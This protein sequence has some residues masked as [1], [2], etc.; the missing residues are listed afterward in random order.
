MLAADD[1]V[2]VVSGRL[3]VEVLEG[4]ADDS[5]EALEAR[6]VPALPLRAHVAAVD[7]RLDDPR[8]V[9]GVEAQPFQRVDVAA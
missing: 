1:E 9:F 5:E 6:I 2:G 7:E 3:S 8:G 4:L